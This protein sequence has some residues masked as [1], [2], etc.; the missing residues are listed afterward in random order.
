[1]H[2]AI[3]LALEGASVVEAVTRAA[4]AAGLERHL[5]EAGADVGRALATLATL[6]IVPGASTYRLEYPVAGVVRS[7]ALAAG[8]V[9]IVATTDAGPILLDFKTDLASAEVLAPY[10]DQVSGYA[11]VIARAF[12]SPRLRAGLLFTFDGHVHWLSSSRD[13]EW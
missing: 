13:G 12:E 5:A 1:V 6:G 3:G 11:R 4:A 9:D 10:V 2:Q 7:G 8:Y